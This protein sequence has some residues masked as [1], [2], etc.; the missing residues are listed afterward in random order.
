MIAG[1]YAKPAGKNGKTFGNSELRRKISDDHVIF[2]AVIPP[3][4][5]AFSRNVGI[6]FVNDS[7]HVRQEGIVLRR[8]FKHR[9][10]NAA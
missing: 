4:P 8:A 10:L 2:L 1:Q 3:V 6:E 9:L 5:G 7:F